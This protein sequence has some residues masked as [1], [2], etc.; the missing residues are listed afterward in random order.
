MNNID[1]LATA[2]GILGRGI[3]LAATRYHARAPNPHC[4]PRALPDLLQMSTWLQTF[5]RFKSDFT[6][7]GKS[8][9]WSFKRLCKG[10]DLVL[11]CH[12][13]DSWHL[14]GVPVRSR[15][16]VLAWILRLLLV[17]GL[18]LHGMH[19]FQLF[20]VKLVARKFEGHGDFL[21]CSVWETG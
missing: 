8:K 21:R 9:N 3:H 17:V 6:I 14:W 16:R 15:T 18:G 13:I 19:L 20:M 7:W 10:A 11:T 2:A 1:L 5:P 4:E 12:D